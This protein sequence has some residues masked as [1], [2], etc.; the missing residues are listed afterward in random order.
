MDKTS[1]LL[2]FT[3]PLHVEFDAQ[4]VETLGLP[5]GRLGVVLDR[6][7]FYPTGGGQE[8]DTGR[9]G[10]ANVLEVFKDEQRGV[11]IH[12]VDRE[13]ATGLVAAAGLVSAAIDRP[14]R[15]RHMQHHT[16][17]HLL[18]H[19][20]IHLLGLE[21]VSANING[22]TPS[23]LD[24]DGDMPGEDAL[25][26]VETLAN[27]V[28][29]EDRPVRTYFVAPEKLQSIPL[30][31][32]PKVSED[33][34][35]VEIDGLDYSA[36]GGT[37]VATTGGIG[38]VKI[39]RTER[40]KD[41]T[42]LH[43]VAGSRA[44]E[45]F[46]TLHETVSGLAAAMSVHPQELT[47]AVERQAEQLKAAQR[48]LGRLHGE[49]L[50]TK[51]RQFYAQAEAHG[52]QRLILAAFTGYTMNDLRLLAKEMRLLPGAVA[53]LASEEAG[54]AE[55]KQ[56]FLVVACAADSSL[57]AQDLLRELLPM[58]NGKGGGDASLAQGGGSAAP[59]QIRSL[60]DAARAMIFSEH[61]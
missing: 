23:T 32:P 19:C 33:I 3:D 7:Y 11:L 31:K 9:L 53:F 55:L 17:Q 44:V 56:V 26:R 48:E 25:L 40:V 4:V 6:T 30:R 8:H 52:D 49:M 35:I 24:L 41:K 51:A 34:R 16:A 50:V 46:Q 38:V 61:A 2:H 14:R 42:R 22:D 18:S 36:C 1:Q 10:D 47:A 57:R 45:Y 58:I 27:Q 12:V 21:T 39:L 15:L 20:C 29:S 60:L 59:G 5:D 43:F 28:I 13:P 54:N 37:H